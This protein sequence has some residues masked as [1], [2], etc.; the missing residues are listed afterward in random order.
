[1]PEKRTVPCRSV[2]VMVIVPAAL[3]ALN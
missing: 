2:T 1:V 3:D